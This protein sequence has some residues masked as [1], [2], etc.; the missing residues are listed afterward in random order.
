MKKI[1]VLCGVACGHE[2]FKA[3]KFP[4]HFF[5]GEKYF[6]WKYINITPSETLHSRLWHNKYITDNWFNICANY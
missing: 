1:I 5:Y 3:R 6:Q 4:R 2:Q